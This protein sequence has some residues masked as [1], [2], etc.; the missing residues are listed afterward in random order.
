MGSLWGTAPSTLLL[1]PEVT[2]ALRIARGCLLTEATRSYARGSYDL[3]FS[4]CGKSVSGQ[5]SVLCNATADG[6]QFSALIT[7]TRDLLAASAARSTPVVASRV[8]LG[9]PVGNQNRER[10]SESRGGV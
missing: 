9:R 5:G 6:A 4:D 1:Y 10:Y 2:G 7:E 3:E 8:A